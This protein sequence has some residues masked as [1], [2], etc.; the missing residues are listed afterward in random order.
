MKTYAA[1]RVPRIFGLY[2]FAAASLC[3]RFDLPLNLS[4]AMYCATLR[5]FMRAVEVEFDT[6][7]ASNADPPLPDGRQRVICHR[8]DLVRTIQT[9]SGPVIVFTSK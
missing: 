9:G 5:F 3:A 6:F 4:T 2:L 7:L 1:G 8:H